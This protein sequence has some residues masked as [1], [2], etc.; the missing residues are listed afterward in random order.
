MATV[1]SWDTILSMPLSEDG[2][3]ELEPE[4]EGDDAEE[5][6]AAAAH[7]LRLSASFFSLEIPGEEQ[8][9]RGVWLSGVLQSVVPVVLLGSAVFTVPLWS[10]TSVLGLAEGTVVL[11]LSRV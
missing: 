7:S 9:A 2:T 5:P 4:P 1:E 3:G 11:G 6:A 8:E 10:G